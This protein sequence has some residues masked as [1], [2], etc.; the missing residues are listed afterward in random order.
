MPKVRRSAAL[1]AVVSAALAASLLLG[2]SDVLRK[3]GKT[4]EAA[5]DF[6]QP[7]TLASAR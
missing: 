4:D 2:L 6:R 1:A 3:L 7:K 5:S